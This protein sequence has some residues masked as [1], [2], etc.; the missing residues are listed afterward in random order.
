MLNLIKSKDSLVNSIPNK[1]EI[2]FI[3]QFFIHKN[4]QR[5]SEISKCLNYICNNPYITTVHLLNERIYT[6]EELTTS[7]SKIVQTNINRRLLYSD[8]FDYVE[9]EELTGYIVFSNSDIFFDE[10]IKNLHISNLGYEKSFYTLLRFEY[11]PQYHVKKSMLFGPRSDS[12]D[13]WIFH[14]KFNVSKKDRCIFDFNFGKPGCD[15]KFVYNL[16]ILGYEV[17]NEPYKIRTYHYHL[18]E[19]RDY[20]SSDVILPPR[21]FIFPK[22]LNDQYK[23]TQID[24]ILMKYAILSNKYIMIDENNKLYHYLYRNISTNKQVILPRIAGIENNV[25]CFAYTENLQLLTINGQF[26][27]I[28]NTMKNNAGIKLTNFLSIMKYAKNYINAF[29]QCE[30]FSVWEPYGNVYPGIKRSHDFITTMFKN[31][32]TSWAFT[33]DLFNYVN[34]QTPWSHALSGKRILL[35][36][37]FKET[38]DKQLLHRNEIYGVDLFPDCT[39]VTLKPPQTQGLNESRDWY[40][41]YMD[42]CKKIDDIKDDFDIA[43]VSCGGYGNPVISYIGSIGKSAIYV[44]GVLQMYFGI[45]GERWVR[46]RP[47]IVKLYKNESWVRPSDAEKPEGFNNVEGSCY[48]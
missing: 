20:T 2:H 21:T 41:E 43:L 10:T 7:S 4:Q 44:G 8:V 9:K 35:I 33:L 28:A 25:V 16:Q 22:V 23:K 11:D 24:D 15:N 17:Y 42:F 3:G 26:D 36:S 32:E 47:E 46:E 29:N 34:I 13:T 38:I 19:I 48:W 30:V 39:F 31:K 37:A 1:E 14:S 27:H 18:T 40:D 45:L 5:Q 12:Q 6:N